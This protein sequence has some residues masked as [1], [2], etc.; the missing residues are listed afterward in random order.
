MR[1]LRFPV[2]VMALIAAT[3]VYAQEAPGFDPEACAKHCREMAA[4]HQK[5][6]DA[7]KAL[8]EKRQATW[9]EIE[10]QLDAARNARGDK[11]VAALES[12]LEK[13]VAFHASTLQAMTGCPMM[14]GH[15][16][17]TMAG[18]PMGCCGGEMKGCCGEGGMG[19]AAH[20][21]ADCPMMKGGPKPP[22][23]SK[24]AH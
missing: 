9:K 8:M 6:V 13:L 15:G 17:G 16:H 4:A 24:P 19:P 18:G 7:Q 11:K 5:D 12:V 14:G 3:A 21:P 2:M 1:K 10:A 20:G 22:E 23:A